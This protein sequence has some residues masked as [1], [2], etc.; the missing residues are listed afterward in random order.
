MSLILSEINIYPVK[1]C[2][3]ISMEAWPLEPRGLQYDRRWMVVDDHDVFMTQ[4]D[5]PRMA[6]IDVHLE[7]D[8]LRLEAPHMETLR[9]PLCT[10]TTQHFSVTI[11]NDG[12]EAVSAGNEAAEWFSEFLSVGCKLVAMTERSVRPVAREYAVNADE[13]SFADGFPLLLISEAS[14]A[15]LNSRLP[16]PLPMKR[17][18]PNLVVQGCAPFAE[19]SW[20]ELSIGGL[21]LHVVKPCARCVITTVNPDT[22]VK[23]AE[24]LRT[25]ATFRSRGNN[26]LFGQNVIPV[27]TGML[28]VGEAVTVMRP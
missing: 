2:R 22:G 3:G 25:L 18:R 4:R 28:R 19:D 23:D 11:W 10:E 27:G 8:F 7:Q 5:F 9:V 12:V 13:V 16:T 6:L 15:D 17:F 21:R 1:S 26:V 20:K 14:L 24:P